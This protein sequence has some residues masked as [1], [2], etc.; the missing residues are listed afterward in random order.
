[1][2]ALVPLLGAAFVKDYAV[3]VGVV[4]AVV[5]LALLAFGGLG[6][7]LGKAPVVKSSLRVLIGGWL[8]MGLTYGLTKLVGSA[9]L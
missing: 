4:I 5:S 2:G 7:L 3:R 1:M 6:A 8:A 9:G